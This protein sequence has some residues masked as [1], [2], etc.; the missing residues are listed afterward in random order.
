MFSQSNS[1]LGMKQYDINAAIYW[2]NQSI[3]L[4]MIIYIYI[5]IYIYTHTHTHIY[6][7]YLLLILDKLC[8]VCYGSSIN[9][10]IHKFAI[11]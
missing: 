10:P 6:K 9:M 4:I 1:T 7:I 8:Q 11:L 5:Y 3:I 2:L